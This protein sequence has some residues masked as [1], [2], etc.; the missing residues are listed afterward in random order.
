MFIGVKL[1]FLN[2]TPLVILTIDKADPIKLMPAMIL[3]S[4]SIY[5]AVEV[6]PTTYFVS[7]DEKSVPSINDPSVAFIMP[8]KGLKKL[9]WPDMISL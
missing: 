6:Y 8:M 7:V 2:L 3:P 9:T 5:I 4:L 1:P